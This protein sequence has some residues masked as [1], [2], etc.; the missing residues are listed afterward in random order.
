VPSQPTAATT[1]AETF[2][3]D[4]LARETASLLTCI[5]G[6][7][8]VRQGDLRGNTYAH[9]IAENGSFLTSPSEIGVQSILDLGVIHAVDLVGL[10]PNGSSV[11]AFE[12]PVLLCLRGSGEIIFLN[13]ATAAR[14]PQR[15]PVTIQG[16]YACV[17]VP[18]A[19][20]VVMVGSAS[21][22]PEPPQPP[23]P[24]AAVTELTGLCRVTTTDAP[25]NLRAE[26]S[27]SAAILAMLPYD[28]TLTA[29]ARVPGWY[30]VIYL[31][32]QGW[33]SDAYVRTTGDCGG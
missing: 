6:I 3:C 16:D 17:S 14:T 23:P 30:R 28:L 25:L 22:M 21:G 13:A 2:F 7:Q 33:V 20:T 10:L 32:M 9:V 1:P 4:N 18:N 29:T 27:R 19:G 5:G 31:D 26:P 8:N 11:V 15:L 12:T 24:T